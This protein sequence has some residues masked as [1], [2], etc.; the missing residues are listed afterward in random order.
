MPRQM[1]MVGFL[2]AQNCSNLPASWR[3]PESRTDLLS[4]DFYR[5]IA[6][7]LEAGQFLLAFFDDRL[8]IPDRYGNEHLDPAQHG[9]PS[10]KMEPPVLL[11][12]IGLATK[13]LG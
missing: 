13:D 8:A 2:Q 10:G 7:V 3:H 6:R 4:A 1:A 12:T 9:I 5:E 11:M